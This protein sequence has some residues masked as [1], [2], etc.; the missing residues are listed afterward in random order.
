[1]KANDIYSTQMR[2]NDIYSKQ[3]RASDI[4]NHKWELMIFTVHKQAQ[5][6]LLFARFQ[7]LIRND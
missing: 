2:A 3:M 7:D 4:Y 6:I 1:M 5:T